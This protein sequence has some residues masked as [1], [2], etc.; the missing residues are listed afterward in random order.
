M[1]SKKL[2]VQEATV[3]GT[4]N[5]DKWGK[6]VPP[7]GWYWSFNEYEEQVLTDQDHDIEQS[8]CDFMIADDSYLGA[9]ERVQMLQEI[10]DYSLRDNTAIIDAGMNDKVEEISG[11][12]VTLYQKLWKVFDEK[13]EEEE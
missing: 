3:W 5:Y 1:I 13:F 8:D 11:A 7:Y 10:V 6:C 9:I 12:L 4:Y 2:N